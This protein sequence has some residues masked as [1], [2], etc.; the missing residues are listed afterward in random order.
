MFYCVF[1]MATFKKSIFSKLMLCSVL[2][3]MSFVRARVMWSSRHHLLNHFTAH[4][5]DADGCGSIHV[6]LLQKGCCTGTD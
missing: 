6:S 5:N 1:Y 2:E 3:I 4:Q